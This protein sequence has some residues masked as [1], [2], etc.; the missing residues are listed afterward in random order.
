MSVVVLVFSSNI[1]G[2]GWPDIY[3][4]QQWQR[5]P[6]YGMSPAKPDCIR[7]KS[8]VMITMGVSGGVG[9]LIGY[10]VPAQLAHER[11]FTNI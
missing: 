10:A 6:N 4:C 3:T 8:V 7:A 11:A 9:F 2:A 1:F 5:G